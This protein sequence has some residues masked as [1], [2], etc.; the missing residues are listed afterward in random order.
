MQD[1]EEF[2]FYACEENAE[3]AQAWVQISHHLRYKV[4]RMD[5]KA[6]EELHESR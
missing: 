6:K 4:E 3:V 2:H 1:E 5:P